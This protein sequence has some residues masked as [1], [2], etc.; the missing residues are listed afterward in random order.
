[1]NANIVEYDS[2]RSSHAAESQ[3]RVFVQRLEVFNDEAAILIGSI[4]WHVVVPQMRAVEKGRTK[5]AYAAL[6]RLIT[7]RR[8][9]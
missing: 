3:Q 5:I 4:G 9:L 8:D 7:W 1:M 2:T 6:L